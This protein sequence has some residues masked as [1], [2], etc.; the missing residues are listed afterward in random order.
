MKEKI[1]PKSDVF[2]GLFSVCLVQRLGGCSQSETKASD[3]VELPEKYLLDNT[4]N[5]P[6]QIIRRERS[7]IA[8]KNCL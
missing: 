5:N 4:S 7:K 8:N 3:N 1:R 6:T 2:L